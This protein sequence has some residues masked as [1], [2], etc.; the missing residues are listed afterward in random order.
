MTP[1]ELI[2]AGAIIALTIFTLIS[3]K[4]Q[5]DTSRTDSNRSDYNTYY[6]RRHSRK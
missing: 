5:N 4:R 2:L 1:V 3:I 6:F